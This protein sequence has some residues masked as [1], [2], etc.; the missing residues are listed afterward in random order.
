MNVKL[1]KQ[2]Q[3]EKHAVLSSNLG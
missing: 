1:D 3:Q 2:Q